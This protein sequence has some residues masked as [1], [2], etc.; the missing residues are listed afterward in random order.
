MAFSLV[1]FYSSRDGDSIDIL[2]MTYGQNGKRG[3]QNQY[4]K[5]SKKEQKQTPALYSLVE[6]GLYYIQ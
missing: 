4:T 6:G 3:K 5:K 1:S 2:V